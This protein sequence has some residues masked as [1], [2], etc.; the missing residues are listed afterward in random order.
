MAES[1]REPERLRSFFWVGVCVLL[2]I[3]AFFLW[4]EHRAH[5]LGVLPW[6]LVLACPAMH[7]FMHRKHGGHE[8][9]HHEDRQQR[10]DVP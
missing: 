4:Q 7:F 8:H 9:H 2:A 5:L 3:A 10:G 1:N 6:L